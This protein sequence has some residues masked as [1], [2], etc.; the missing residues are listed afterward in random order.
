MKSVAGRGQRSKKTKVLGTPDVVSPQ[1]FAAMELDAKVE[2]IQALIPLGLMVVSETLEAE[3]T[4]LAG[5]RYRREGGQAG[6][7][8]HGTNPGSVR[9]GDSVCPFVCLACGIRQRAGKCL[10]RRW[11]PSGGRRGR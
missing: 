3:V 8:R 9:L 6:L 7:V 10:W 4:A 2:L 11:R 5:E 1:E